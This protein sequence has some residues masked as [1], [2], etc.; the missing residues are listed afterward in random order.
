MRLE[1]ALNTGREGITAHGQAIAVVG[2]NISNAN[3][4]AYKTQR[5]IFSD[6]LGE[7][8]DDRTSEV[9]TG[10]GDGVAIRQVQTNFETSA[11]QVTGRDL[12]I[13]LDGNGFFMCGAVD[14]VQLTRSGSLALDENGML[15]TSF[16]LPVLGY[17]GIDT[18]TLTPI[19]MKKVDL[20]ITPTTEA[21]FYGNMNSS[22]I[23]TVAPTNPATFKDVNAQAAFTNVASVYDSLGER[24]EILF[25]YYKTGVNSW[26]VQGYVNGSETGGTA[27]VPVKVGETTLTFDTSGK[28]L[29]GTE[30]QSILK[31]NATWANGGGT[32]AVNIDLSSV[33]QFAGASMINNITQNG[34]GKGDIIGY[35]V[36]PA[37]G[38]FALLSNGAK[39]QVGSLAVANVTNKDGL[40]RSGT[41]TYEATSKAGTVEAGLAG[42]GGRGRVLGRSL[43]SSNVD[44]AG[45]F[46]DLVVLQRGYTANSKVISTASE[47]IKDT[48]SLVR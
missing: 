44:L 43:E 30:A 7:K 16:G 37:G 14:K 1:S 6:I 26:K 20:V 48:I 19:D 4:T 21:K 15:V 28:I 47:I 25:A 10:G 42:V 35:Q 17:Q 45:Q 3:T 27:E 23:T 36:S 31:V 18:A 39:A 11:A 38:I 33:T 41:S 12:D 13:A 9:I 22:S 32:S 8:Q 40:I 46:V 5:A 24:H 34:Q 2:D 29:Q